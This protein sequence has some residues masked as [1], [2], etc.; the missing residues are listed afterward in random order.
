MQRKI[1]LDTWASTNGWGARDR[2]FS[3]VLVRGFC[4]WLYEAV[5]GTLWDI[6]LQVTRALARG[7][8]EDLKI[9]LC[10]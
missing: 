2:G 8:A 5:T 4:K 10:G 9:Q 6:L 1:P 3:Q 7:L